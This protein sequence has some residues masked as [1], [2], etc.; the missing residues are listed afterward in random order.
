VTLI[1]RSRG[2]AHRALGQRVVR[3]PAAAGPE[4]GVS[5]GPGPVLRL[6][7]LGESTAAGVGAA[8]HDEGL[9]GSLARALSE[10]TSR[11]V[12]WSVTAR[13][14]ATTRAAVEQLAPQLPSAA[15]GDRADLVV[16]FLGVN[17]LVRLTPARAWQRDIT[18]LL[19]A[20]RQRTALAPVLF[21]GVPPVHR[22][23]AMP[24]PLAPLLAR[25]VALLDSGLSTVAARSG[26]HHE[27]TLELPNDK[28]LFASDG[29]HPAPSLYQLW[30]Q[31]LAPT[32]SHLAKTFTAG[33]DQL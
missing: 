3:L 8:S 10:R 25:R 4:Q 32:A 33:A 2:A 5:E 23:P 15:A 9:A 1:A 7:L 12:A 19:A 28:A 14:G 20:I 21:A 29:F 22:F 24:R 13:S 18:D 17:D 26:A 31:Q 16:V 6:C 27:A 30:A 11:R